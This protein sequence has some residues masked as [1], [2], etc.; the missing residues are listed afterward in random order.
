M[1]AG[2]TGK[3]NTNNLINID[4]IVLEKIRYDGEPMLH[5]ACHSKIRC[6]FVSAVVERFFLQCGDTMSAVIKQFSI[7]RE[8]S[9]D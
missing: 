2:K 8:S 6:L 4:L 1:H 3:P 7:T 5:D 9:V